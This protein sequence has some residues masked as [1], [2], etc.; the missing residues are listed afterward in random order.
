[1]TRLESGANVAFGDWNEVEGQRIADELK[2]RIY[3][4]KCDVSKWDDVG[5][6][7]FTTW[8]KFGTIHAVISNAGV[9]THEG[10]LE[11]EYDKET[12]I[13]LP[14]K[15]KSIEINL[16]GQLYVAKC[17]LHFNTHWPDVQTQLVLT[18]SAGAFFPAPPIHMYCAA[19]SGVLGFMRALRYDV[20]KKKS[21]IN[22][23]APWL[24]STFAI[25]M[26]DALLD[27]AVS[28]SLI[29]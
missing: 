6:L 8:K 21:T 12:G 19:K 26:Q 22:V 3:F 16:I 13:L 25:P 7:F 15:L 14:P 1:M 29:G 24:T 27:C 17:A 2:D 18:A 11:D 28:F 20:P 9:N 4:K 23:V 5:S 10:F